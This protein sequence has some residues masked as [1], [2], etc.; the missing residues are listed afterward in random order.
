MK[1]LVAIKLSECVIA[2]E[3]E[4]DGMTTEAEL[5]RQ[6]ITRL[7]TMIEERCRELWP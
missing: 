6:A 3:I 5:E 1:V 7:Q 2:I 4:S